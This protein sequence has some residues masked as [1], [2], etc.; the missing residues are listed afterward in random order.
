MDLQSSLASPERE[1]TE[2]KL[3]KNCNIACTGCPTKTPT[4]WYTYEKA[5]ENGH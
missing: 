5:I 4:L 3:W 1:L 2:Q